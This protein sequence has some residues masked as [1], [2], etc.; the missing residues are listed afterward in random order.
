MSARAF[1]Y[2]LKEKTQVYIF[3]LGLEEKGNRKIA[4]RTTGAKGSHFFKLFNMA[5]F[6]GI[7]V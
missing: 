4:R 7:I 5:L 2:S 1:Q 3:M 6:L